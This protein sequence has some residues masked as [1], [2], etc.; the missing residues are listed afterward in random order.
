MRKSQIDLRERVR[1]RDR[2]ADRPPLLERLR[3]ERGFTLVELMIA[4]L[5]LLAA[6][7]PIVA[8]IVSS[9]QIGAKT[10]TQSDA[11]ALAA[12]KIELIRAMP[13]DSIGF[14]SGNPPGTITTTNQLF[15][16]P[17]TLNGQAIAISYQIA[18]V[19][20]HGA[21]TQTYADYKRVIVTITRTSDNV[22][23][24][25]K[26]TNVAALTGA[27][28][29]GSEYLTI[30]RLL[31]D[32]AGG[33]PA[34]SDVAVSVAHGP[35]AARTDST[36]STG[37]VVFPLLTPNT[38]TSNF[39]DVTAALAGYSTYP[40]DLPYTGTANPAISLEHVNHQTGY[41]DLQTIHM[42]KNGAAVTVTVY[43]SDGVTPFPSAATVYMGSST[44]LAGNTATATV[45]SP[46]SAAFSQLQLG[47]AYVS[48]TV[49]TIQIFP[50]NYAFSAQYGNT[51]AMTYAVPQT[52]VAVPTNYPTVLTKTVK[53]TMYPNPQT[54]NTTLTITVKRGSTAIQNAH[55]EVS[56]TAT[57]QTNAPSV[58]LWGNTNSS[59]QVSL[60]VPRGNG[61]T[62]KATD[63]RG[64]TVSLV[65][66]SYSSSTG[67]ATLTITP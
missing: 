13:Y 38:S 32:M 15:Y 56:S 41:D 16:G 55:V 19:D 45:G 27:A 59:G 43:K 25:S 4:T 47:N 29:G 17:S 40:A 36:S 66:Q 51:V 20:D 44:G 10:L 58:Y 2:L 57:G 11:S 23:L 52:T 35:S 62:L 34:L 54:S 14:P 9:S 60:I 33:S 61:F 46:T 63:A 5:L 28:G 6:G 22:V 12:A 49:S 21:K 7:P 64:S 67:S 18:F 42:Y 39:Y 48:P 65:N 26:T 1:P 31:V 24:A 37:S 50:G 8:V 3:G 30:R 53:L